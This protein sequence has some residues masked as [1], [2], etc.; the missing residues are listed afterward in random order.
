MKNSLDT[1]YEIIKLVKKSPRRDATF[2]R[3]KEELPESSPGIRVL[4]PTRWTVQAQ[5]LQS[6]IRNYQVLLQ[7]WEA[8]LEFVKEAE[9]RSRIQGVSV[10]MQSFEF[11]FGLVLAELLLNHSDNLSK[12]LQSPRLSAAQGQKI[13]QMTVCTL[14]SLRSDDNF[15]LFWTKVKKMASD[16][17]VNNPVLPRQRKRPRRYEDGSAEGAFPDKVEDLYRV[18]YFEA[19]D[20]IVNCIK[21]RFDQ[22]GYQQYRKLEELLVNAANKEPYDEHLKQITDFYKGDFDTRILELQ[23]DV[24]ACNIPRDSPT[25]THNLAS[26][27][28]YLRDCFSAQKEL[29][30]EV[31]KVV[32]LV[33]VMPATNAL[34][35]RSFSSLRRVKSYLR[36]TMTQ[37]RLNHAMVLHVHRDLTDNLSLVEVANDFVS[38]SEHRRTQFG[39][40]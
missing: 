15:L 19:I 23:L 31:C 10:C 27:L 28:Q 20:L 25:D 30:S 1:A 29:M 24:M 33:L 13:A 35:E 32:S 9:M 22:P 14:Q 11:F 18:V 26:V 37:A 21:D 5:A 3:L 38:K 39:R 36:S 34:S 8:S 7:L 40:L 16:L 6:I 4:C 12:T 17:E 2:Q